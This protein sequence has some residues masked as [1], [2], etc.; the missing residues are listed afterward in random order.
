MQISAAE[1]RG[2]GAVGQRVPAPSEFFSA[3]FVQR[4]TSPLPHDNDHGGEKG[5]C[6]GV[7]P[8]SSRA[9]YFFRFV[10]EVFEVPAASDLCGL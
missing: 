4:D 8:S 5:A 3:V 2:R 6:S 10:L 1:G 9:F 7:D